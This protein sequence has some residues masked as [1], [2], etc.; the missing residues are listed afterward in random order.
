MYVFLLQSSQKLV[1]EVSPSSPAT[2]SLGQ[3][4]NSQKATLSTGLAKVCPTAHQ[5][6]LGLVG[7]RPGLRLENPD[8][9]LG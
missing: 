1:L 5:V 8:S 4:G 2:V 7:P 6:S 3:R 9:M